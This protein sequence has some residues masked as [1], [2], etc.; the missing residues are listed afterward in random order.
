MTVAGWWCVPSVVI[1]MSEVIS[2][3]NLFTIPEPPKG[4]YL[5]IMYSPQYQPTVYDVK[6]SPD[7]L[8]RFVRASDIRFVKPKTE[9]TGKSKDTEYVS[10][11]VRGKSVKL[12]V[13]RFNVVD[14]KYFE[15]PEDIETS[16]HLEGHCESGKSCRFCKPRILVVHMKKCSIRDIMC[17]VN[18]LI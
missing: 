5:I 13:Y 16:R 2:L 15:D 10:V 18:L 8:D 12:G 9:G 3:Y 14:T 7:D 17:N 11:N 4:G 1:A 6:L